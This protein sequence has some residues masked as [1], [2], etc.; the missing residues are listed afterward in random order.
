MYRETGPIFSATA[1]VNATTSCLVRRS[2]SSMRGTSAAMSKLALALISA[3]ASF[4]TTPSSAQASQA[5]ISMVSQSENRFAGSQ[6]AAIFGREYRGIISAPSGKVA[7]PFQTSGGGF[8]PPCYR[9]RPDTSSAGYH[10]QT[11]ETTAGRGYHQRKNRRAAPRNGN[12]PRPCT[13]FDCTP[14]VCF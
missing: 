12:A 8:P 4:G 7:L 10:R 6:M 14:G 11:A 13:Y 2:I 3:T 9:R 5:R 1:S